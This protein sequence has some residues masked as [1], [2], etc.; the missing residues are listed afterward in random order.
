MSANQSNYLTVTSD[1]N[2]ASESK[3]KR[4]KKNEMDDQIQSIPSSLIISFKNQEGSNSGTPSVDL[5][6]SSTSKQLE[7]LI[8]S[9]LANQETVSFTWQIFY[10]AKNLSFYNTHTTFHITPK[11]VAICILH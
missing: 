5:P 8:N 9:L 7:L 2:G 6:L 4:Q 3:A 1:V 10:T 11:S